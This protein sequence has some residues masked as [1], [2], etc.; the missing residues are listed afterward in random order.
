MSTYEA[1]ELAQIPLDS[2]AAVQER[3]ELLI[4]AACRRQWWMLLLDAADRQLPVIIPM[5]GYPT[6]PNGGA[7]ETLSTRIGETLEA[8]GATQVVFVWERPG[9]RR[10]SHLDRSWAR[11]LGASC[12][13]AGITVR[14]QLISHD[15]GVRWMA[16]DDIL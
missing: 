7:A 15:G 12:A 6:T 3:V 1:D 14:A 9:G 10:I 13:A 5:A 2:D 8:C 11:A 4:G 16:P